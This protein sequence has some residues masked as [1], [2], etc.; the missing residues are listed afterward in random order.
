MHLAIILF[1]VIAILWSRHVRA[2]REREQAARERAARA[3]LEAERAEAAYRIANGILLAQQVIQQ[4]APR[5][6]AEPQPRKNY[7]L[8]R[9]ELRQADG[10]ETFRRL[11]D[12]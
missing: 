5:A 12:Q 3:R 1:I 10:L 7:Y 4:S 9:A 8:E 11:M 6:V 2:V